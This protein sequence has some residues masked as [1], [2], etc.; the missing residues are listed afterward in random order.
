MTAKIH[1][2][3][4]CLSEE[5]NHSY[6]RLQNRQKQTD[7]TNAVLSSLFLSKTSSLQYL[8][9]QKINT[10]MKE[11]KSVVVHHSS[12]EACDHLRQSYGRGDVFFTAEPSPYQ[13]DVIIHLDHPNKQAVEKRETHASPNEIVHMLISGTQ[14]EL[15]YYKTK[16]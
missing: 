14:Q 5:E 9:F 11:G 4:V 12:Q 6:L 1:E 13:C 16:K 3:Y 10:C 2:F 15:E 7:D 8:L